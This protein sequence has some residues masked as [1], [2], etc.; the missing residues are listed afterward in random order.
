MREWTSVGTYLT[1]RAELMPG[2]DTQERTFAVARVLS[3][4]RVELAGLAGEQTE[5]EFETKALSKR[6]SNLQR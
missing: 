6:F 4:K 3:N 1:F 5:A 2:R